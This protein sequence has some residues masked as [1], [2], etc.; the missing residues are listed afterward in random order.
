[1]VGWGLCHIPEKMVIP[2]LLDLV[3]F[4]SWQVLGLSICTNLWGPFHK[5]SSVLASNTCERLPVCCYFRGGYGAEKFY[6]FPVVVGF[7]P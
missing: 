5:V 2:L 6:Q 4:C 3:Q 7:G 1:M